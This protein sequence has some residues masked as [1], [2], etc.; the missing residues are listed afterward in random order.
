MDYLEHIFGW[1]NLVVTEQL[2][3]DD[4][5][6]FVEAGFG[7]Q[8]LVRRF[9]NVLSRYESNAAVLSCGE[10]GISVTYTGQIGHAKFSGKL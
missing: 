8:S 9:S 3:P 6:V 5:Q 7:N 4:Q 1:A 10:R 2:R